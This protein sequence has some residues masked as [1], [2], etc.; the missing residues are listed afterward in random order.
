MVLLT[1]QVNIILLVSCLFI[2]QTALEIIPR[3]DPKS[4]GPYKVNNSLLTST[5]DSGVTYD[6]S[7][8]KYS[9]N[10]TSLSK[11]D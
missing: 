2:S 1:N 4:F 5:L 3:L 8:S 11:L 10:L 6:Q 9:L 7:T